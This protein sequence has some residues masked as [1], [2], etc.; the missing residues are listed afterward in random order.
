[1]LVSQLLE[2]GDTLYFERLYSRFF[3][4]VYYQVLAYVKEPHEAQ[5]V[6][7]DIFV[8]L[9]DRLGKFQGKSS[10]STWLYT[11]ARNTVLDH[12]RKK[13]KIQEQYIEDSRLEAIPEVAD[14]ELLQIRSEKLAYIL[15]QVSPDEKAIL[16]MMYA[17]EWKMDEIAE[18][19]GVSLSAIKMRIKR[20]KLK[21][22]ELYESTYGNQ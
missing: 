6:A 4:K 10:F 12:L 11:F 5:D 15:D 14:E 3:K 19:M 2:T 18:V 1:M 8:K 13:G 22:R 17:N 21:V 16:I 9:Y 20:A 7:Q